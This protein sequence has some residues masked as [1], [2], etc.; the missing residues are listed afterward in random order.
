MLYS[1]NFAA[2]NF[3]NRERMVA[4]YG[5]VSTEHEAQLSAL[6]NQIDW[7]KPIMEAHPEWHVVAQYIDEGI[8]G[9]SAEK[10]EAFL[11]MINDAKQH[12]FDLIITR[13]VSRFARNTVDTLQYTRELSRYGVE[14]FFLNDNIKTFDGDGELRLTI[15]ATLAQDES[16]KT[17]IRVKSGQQTSM[18]KGVVYGNGNILGYKRVGKEMIID[19]EQAKTVRLIFDLYLS[20]WGLK[21]IKYELEQRGIKTAL[22]KNLWSETVISHILQNT[23]YYGVMT[24]HKEYIMDF[25][26]QKRVKNKGE[27]GLTQ[28]PGT[29][30]PIITKEEYD[31]VQQI[32]A[33]KKHTYNET[34]NKPISKGR[35]PYKSV[36]G[37]LMICSCGYKFSRHIYSGAG[38]QMQKY[39]F[40][41]YGTKLH[42]SYN[43]RK[44]KGLPLDGICQVSVIPE[45]KLMITANY[46][47]TKYLKKTDTVLSLA[48]SIIKQH[49]NDTECIEDNTDLIRQLINEKDKLGKKVNN[50]IEMRSDGE[51]SK[52]LFQSKVKEAEE[53]IKEIEAKIEALTPKNVP[54]TTDYSNKLGQLCDLLDRYVDFEVGKDINES[55]IE[56]FIKKIVVYP[57]HYEWYLRITDDDNEP[58]K[59]EISGNKRSGYNVSLNNELQT[60][61]CLEQ[62]RQLSR[63]NSKIKN[64]VPKHT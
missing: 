25:L 15:M 40:T 58:L 4:I 60:T 49:I 32:M 35:Q 57:D 34:W 46:I 42:G 55:I 11:R 36:W 5:R 31:R 13:E 64:I 43:S 23:F 17:S 50:L 6:E 39:G 37:R 12:K 14:V 9:T 10:R 45:Q 3:L 61:P 59:S 30:E 53:R 16:R 44:K 29:H 26:S 8:T 47:F 28:T 24:Y 33:Q 51:I 41:C 1:Q 21:K 56:A 20:G 62:H 52:E 63:A 48:K 38:T 18:E 19:P 2:Q 7:Y 54:S 27:L 22:G